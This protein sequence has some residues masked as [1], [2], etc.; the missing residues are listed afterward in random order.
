MPGIP[1]LGVGRD[2]RISGACQSQS[3]QCVS[4]RFS[5][6][7]CL[8]NIRRKLGVVAYNFNARTQGWK[9]KDP[10]ELE[11]SLVSIAG[12]RLA[13]E[14]IGIPCLK[15]TKANNSKIEMWRM[16]EGDT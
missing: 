7:S 8:K 3:I 10:C 5:E 12:S 14:H 2:R 11:G 9:R 4:S 15:G 1:A 16:M 6:K 13:W